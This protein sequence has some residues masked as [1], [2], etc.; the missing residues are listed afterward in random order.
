MNRTFI[1]SL[2]ILG[3]LAGCGDGTMPALPEAGG[4]V[5]ATSETPTINPLIVN[6]VRTPMQAMLDVIQRCPT[7]ISC[8]PNMHTIY[9]LAQSGMLTGT[10]TPSAV[11]APNEEINEEAL[12]QEASEIPIIQPNLSVNANTLM[13]FQSPIK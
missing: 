9:E 3:F 11:V 8:N 7:A 4:P 2:I 6:T 10:E 12:A 1:F 5:A 13:M